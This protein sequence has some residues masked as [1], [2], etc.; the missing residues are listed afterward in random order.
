MGGSNRLGGVG[1]G[2]GQAGNSRAGC[3]EDE[4][5]ASEPAEGGRG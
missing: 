5:A 4:R 3:G 1:Q 2:T